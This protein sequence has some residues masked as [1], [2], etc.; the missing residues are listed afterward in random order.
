MLYEVIT[1]LVLYFVAASL[2]FR[3]GP[4]VCHGDHQ[5][6]LRNAEFSELLHQPPDERIDVALQAGLQIA[7]G[8]G[9]FLLVGKKT[10]EHRPV[11]HIEWLTGLGVSLDE[12]Q[13]A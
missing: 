7:S 12:F 11:G 9:A 10:V 4:V 1:G 3:D 2:V 6:V 5:R 8:Y 13:R